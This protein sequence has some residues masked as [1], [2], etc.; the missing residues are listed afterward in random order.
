MFNVGIKDKINECGEMQNAGNRCAS[1]IN[2]TLNDKT[3]RAFGDH[4]SNSFF[5][6]HQKI[7]HIRTVIIIIS[8][9]PRFIPLSHDLYYKFV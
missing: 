8:L 3:S 9:F 6:K 7:N 1:D 5:R 4:E 2:A